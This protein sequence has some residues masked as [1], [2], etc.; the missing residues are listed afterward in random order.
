MTGAGPASGATAQAGE[1]P[2]NAA[3]VA[4]PGSPAAPRLPDPFAP[5]AATLRRLQAEG[6]PARILRV[7]APWKIVAFSRRDEHD[8]RFPDAARSAREC[9]FQ[10]AVRPVGGT[11]AP[12]HAGSL[13]V[14]E[15]GFTPGEQRP[16]KRFERHA[17]LLAEV[18]RC[19]GIDARVGAVPGEYCPGAHSVNRGGVAKLSGT[20]QR[21][22]RGA[23]LVSS[24]VQV[25]DAEPLRSVAAAVAGAL[26]APIDVATIGALDESV[27]AIDV[28]EVG[29]RVV[30][31]FVDSGVESVEWGI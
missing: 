16:R 7:W 25:L 31:A 28:D 19:Y 24:V 3:A 11:F 8:P 29:V 5:V 18:F 9:G 23:W 21:V 20:A 4:S 12:L 6:R 22:S 1:Q 15:F 30:A 27:P 13:V 14:D 2:V 17:G 10:A 26:E